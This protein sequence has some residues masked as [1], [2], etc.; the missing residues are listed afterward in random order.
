MVY[1]VVKSHG[2]HI[3]CRSEPGRGT[4]FTIH[5]PALEKDIPAPDVP[6]R[7]RSQGGAETILLV[8][9]EQFIREVGVEILTSFGYSVLTAENGQSAIE[10]Y[11]GR[12]DGIDLVIMDLIMPGIGGKDCLREILAMDPQAKVLITNGFAP[13]EPIQET[14]EAGARGFIGKPYQIE[15]FLD[16]IRAVLDR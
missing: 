12:G 14:M 16:S 11:R 4:T 5:F 2:G 13:N 3:S 1:G 15:Q 7:V 10:I 9:D 8:D 6:R